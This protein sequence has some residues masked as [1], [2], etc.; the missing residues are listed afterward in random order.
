MNSKEKLCGSS[1]LIEQVERILWNKVAVCSR[2]A[3]TFGIA[4]SFG[5]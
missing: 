4:T 2:S 5:L 1:L 3:D